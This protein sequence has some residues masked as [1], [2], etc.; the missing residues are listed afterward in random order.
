MALELRLHSPAGAEAVV[1]Q[2][3]LSS[4][5]GSD[6][7]DGALEIVETIRW[8]CEDLPELKLPLENNILCDYDTRSYESMKNLCDRYNRA[9]D[10][11]V[12][13]EKGTSL[14]AQRLNKHPSRGLLRHILQQVYNQAVTDP[15]KLNQYEPFSPEVYGE[16]SYDLV[17]QMIDQI[18][19]TK[20][21]VFVD[22][23]SG[24]GQVVLQMAAATPCKICFGVERAEIPSMYAEAMNVH[25]RK[26]M[27]WYG[28]KYGEYRLIK[29]DFLNDEHREKIISA[30]IVFVNNF[31]FGP[32]VDH[33]LKE[34]FADLKDGARIVSSK[35]FCPLNF[36]ITDRNL[37]DIGTIMHVSEMT[38]LRGSVSWTNKPV[39]YY[40][41]IIDRAKLE[42]YFQGLKNPK[43]KGGGAAA[44][45]EEENTPPRTSRDRARRDLS[46]QLN[47]DTSSNSSH[48]SDDSSALVTSRV[49]TGPTT[50]RAWSDWCSSKGKSS[51]SEEE[52]NNSSS[53]N[54]KAKARHPKKLRRKLTRVGKQQPPPPQQIVNI[55]P[56]R[57]QTK[58]GARGRVKKGKSKKAIKIN[59]LDLLHS[60]TLLSTSPQ[61]IGKKLPPAPGCVDQQLTSLSLNTSS[62]HEELDIPPAPAETP[63]ALQILLDLYRAQFL[64]M[65]D[66]MKNPAFRDSVEVQ[67][68]TE[69]ER[70]LKLMSRAA[71]LEKQIKVLIDDSVALLKARMCELGINASS[72]GDLLAKAKEIVLRHKELQAKA[73][74][75]QAQVSSLEQDQAKYM[76]MRQQEILEKYR[77][78]GIINGANQ[79]SID[80]SVL[81][82]DYILKEISATLT[83]RKKLRTK[84]SRLET[85]LTALQKVSEDRKPQLSQFS[86]G[87]RIQN[88]TGVYDGASPVADGTASPRHSLQATA[89]L[90]AHHGHSPVAKAQRKSRENRSRSQDWPDV[91]DIGKI[92]E[93]N[94]EILAQKILETG[95]QIEAGKIREVPKF[96]GSHIPS[97]PQPETGT[98]NGDLTRA[99]NRFREYGGTHGYSK[100]ESQVATS[101]GQQ[102]S[103]AVPTDTKPAK[104]P[105]PQSRPE[106][107][108]VSGGRGQEPPRVA[109]FEDRLKS[110]ITSVLNEDQQNR[111]QQTSHNLQVPAPPPPSGY[112]HITNVTNTVANTFGTSGSFCTSGNTS[113]QALACGIVNSETGKVNRDFKKGSYEGER[114]FRRESREKCGNP[115]GA[116]P[117]NV[118]ALQQP[119]YTQVSPAKLALRRHLSQ[120]K[121]AAA[122][123]QQIQSLGSGEKGFVAT[124]TIGDLVNGEIERTLEISNQSIINAAVDMSSMVVGTVSS[125]T[126]VNQNIPRPERVN[127][128]VTR[129]VEENVAR[130]DDDRISTCANS[131][132]SVSPPRRTPVYS[133][134]SRPSSAE[135]GIIVPGNPPTPVGNLQQ[136][137]PSLEGLAYPQHRPKSPLNRHPHHGLATLAHVAYDRVNSG[138]APQPTSVVP[139]SFSPRTTVLYPL[140]SSGYPQRSAPHTVSSASC[141]YATSCTEASFSPVQLPRAD[142]KPYHE[143]YFSDTK[144]PIIVSAALAQ[145]DHK[146]PV[147][148]Q[149]EEAATPKPHYSGSVDDGSFAPV[150]GLAATLRARILGD[151]ETATPEHVR[152]PDSLSVKIEVEDSAKRSDCM[153]YE[154]RQ[155]VQRVDAL[156]PEHEYEQENELEEQR[157]SDPRYVTTLS[158]DEAKKMRVPHSSTAQSNTAIIQNVASTVEVKTEVVE[159]STK[160]LSETEESFLKSSNVNS[161]YHSNKRASPVIQGPVRHHKKQHLCTNS[162]IPAEGDSGIS[163]VSSIGPTLAINAASSPELNSGISTPSTP[164]TSA[165]GEQGS[166][167]SS[168]R[169]I[170]ER[171]EEMDEEEADGRKVDKWQ[172]KISSGFD[173][174][175]SF[176]STELD[177]RRRSTEGSSPRAGDV[178][179]SCNTSPDSGIGHGDP[180]QLPSTLPN[181]STKKRS[182]E[183][184][185]S[186]PG[187]KMPRLFKTPTSKPSPDRAGRDSPPVL[188]PPLVED[189]AGP[190]RTPSPSSAD[191]PPP[192]STGP[193]F[194]PAPL[195]GPYSPVSVTS[196][197]LTNGESCSPPPALPPSVPIRYHRSEHGDHKSRADHHFKKKFFH[198]ENWTSSNHWQHNAPPAGHHSHHHKGK[199]RPKGKDWEW[200]GT[201]GHHMSAGITP[202]FS[203]PP[204]HLVN[205]SLPPPYHPHHR[206]SSRY[207]GHQSWERYGGSHDG[208]GP[209]SSID[210]GS[211]HHLT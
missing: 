105:R 104:Q 10:S 114:Q 127:V 136:R 2:W 181:T 70:N 37:S 165:A 53:N 209:D 9:I 210:P 58:R 21:D 81:T 190:P 110:I 25:F 200:H 185:G 166:E 16:T 122:S 197:P 63:Y 187:P 113:S 119:D 26:W 8:V 22:L 192:V 106:P 121:L 84:V 34:R 125:A 146:P 12:Q 123:A 158:S 56:P 170:E 92:E 189:T 75:L 57:A 186:S 169:L 135:G 31:A 133:P 180:P 19:I 107:T 150:E 103:C 131:S 91:P 82:Q 71:Q 183:V 138:Y 87:S 41:H 89:G 4:G 172:D 27:R 61:A 39:S 145:Q 204:P 47:L 48:D 55:P 3:P 67:I 159:G 72:P 164:S 140:P 76:S 36:R 85:E 152:R 23:G 46:K 5:T 208:A 203:I 163:S 206:H 130:R 168:S 11:I 6:K 116:H 117:R 28:K 199:F 177:K 174:L 161:Q 184:G 155:Q 102:R 149:S 176:A 160:P 128:R 182:L 198:R 95:R 137:A 64:Q 44:G 78:A 66:M 73:S 141:R 45:G 129:V 7:H 69:K 124:R 43:L 68:E 32:T 62:V 175:M 93:N 195:D 42:R 24:V 139:R 126:V 151:R 191:E 148:V 94:P 40:L 132:G 101:R 144:P 143:S 99:V 86:S 38:P 193:S 52:N 157:I 17:C 134:I 20:D 202:D 147:S 35:S 194:S 207:R 90:S 115:G 33:M 171:D 167:R 97:L 111:Q 98:S 60:Q 59:G 18:E 54:G 109:N 29:G 142:I 88:G 196:V 108:G 118:A 179:A 188:E 49:V 74:K 83:H 13:L 120:E 96:N 50:R 156:K 1:Y 154:N 14:P 112:S 178:A 205:T 15:E 201:K 65:V 100:H 162:E 80:I 77:K 153:M 211:S 79:G 51:Q 30:T 173:R